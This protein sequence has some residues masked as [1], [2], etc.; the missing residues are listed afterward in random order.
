MGNISF[1]PMA[2][3]G[4][5]NA[6]VTQTGGYVQG[7]FLDDPAMRNQ[8]EGGVVA[9]GQATPLWGGLPITLAIPAAGAQSGN[10]LGPAISEATTSSAV[11]GWTLFNQASAGIITPSSNVPLYS[12]GMSIN[13]AR[14]GSL[15]R[16]ALP[17]LAASANALIGA[18]PTLPVYWDYTN[19][20]L[21]TTQPGSQA[22][23][24]LQVE[25]IDLNSKTVTYNSGTGNA[26][27]NAAAPVAICRI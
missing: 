23:L 14:A 9:T 15:L 8:L 5:P 22:A 24:A 27:W 18:A 25:F 17:V 21:T 4:I 1:N 16:V 20:W 13:F 7:V 2:T 10:A 3:T 6:F 19:Q 26:T 12:S 11:H